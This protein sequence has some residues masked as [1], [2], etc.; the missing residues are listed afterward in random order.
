MIYYTN[1]NSSFSGLLFRNDEVSCFVLVQ[2]YDRVRLT[3]CVKV[4]QGD[5]SGFDLAG[6]IFGHALVHALVSFPGVLNHQG[7][8]FQKIQTCVILHVKGV[9]AK[10]NRFESF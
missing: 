2:P 8:V 9:A 3:W 1:T 6:D 5:L 10:T 7:A 4:A